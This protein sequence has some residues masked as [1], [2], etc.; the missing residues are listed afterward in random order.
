MTLLQRA[1]MA[2][3]LWGTAQLLQGEHMAGSPRTPAVM[4]KPGWSRKSSH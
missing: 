4:A 2:M 1:L 3:R